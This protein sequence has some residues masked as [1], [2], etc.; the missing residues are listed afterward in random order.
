MRAFEILV[1]SFIVGVVVAGIG[2]VIGLG[3]TSIG[4][5]LLWATYVFLAVFFLSLVVAA[6]WD[7]ILAERAAGPALSSHEYL[8]KEPPDPPVR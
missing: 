4:T 6:I 7:F 8:A 1:I 5:A 2:L 3:L